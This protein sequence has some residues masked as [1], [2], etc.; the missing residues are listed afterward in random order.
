MPISISNGQWVIGRGGAG[1]GIGANWSIYP[2]T[3][4][5]GVVLSNDDNLP[6]QDLLVRQEA[7]ITGAPVNLPP[8]G[9]G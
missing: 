8:G 1:P 9:G 3:G 4:W 2:D 6:I 7:A 5:V